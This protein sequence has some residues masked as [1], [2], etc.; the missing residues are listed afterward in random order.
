VAGSEDLIE[1]L[2]QRARTYIYTTALP[3]AIAAATLA[4]LDVMMLESWRREHLKRLI[5]YFREGMIAQGIQVGAFRKASD[6]PVLMSS[7]T[8]IQPLVLGTASRALQWQMHLE[9]QGIRVLAIRP[10]TVPEGTARL[11]ITFSAA[12]EFGQIDRLIEALVH[13]LQQEQHTDYR[14]TNRQGAAS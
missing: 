13:C 5:Q 10:P 11:R 6:H 8:A 2:I 1:Y 9:A 12:H 4:S 7:E 14:L 3:P